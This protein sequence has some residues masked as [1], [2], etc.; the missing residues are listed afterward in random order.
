V[1][2]I[3][4]GGAPFQGGQLPPMLPGPQ[5]RLRPPAGMQLGQRKDPSLRRY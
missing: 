5:P 1:G 4:M 3:G 2:G